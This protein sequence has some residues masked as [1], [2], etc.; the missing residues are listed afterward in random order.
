[1][2]KSSKV[3]VSVAVITFLSEISSIEGYACL[4]SRPSHRRAEGVNLLSGMG[5]DLTRASCDSMVTC[6]SKL[7]CDGCAARG[8]A[9]GAT[10]TSTAKRSAK[11][12]VRPL[13]LTILQ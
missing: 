5:P 6:C 2:G 8:D 11:A 10:G 1:M 3:H 12:L 9:I 4:S 13:K 7:T